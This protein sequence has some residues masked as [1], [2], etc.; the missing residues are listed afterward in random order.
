[1]KLP[2]PELRT[3]LR[4]SGW[5]PWAKCGD[6]QARNQEFGAW[7]LVLDGLDFRFP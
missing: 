5:G 7:D 2:Y 4:G 3:I 1:M 6:G